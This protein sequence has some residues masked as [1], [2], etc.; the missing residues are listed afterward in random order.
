MDRPF[1]RRKVAEIAASL[2]ELP[3]SV[4]RGA[5]EDAIL[6]VVGIERPNG[7][8]V[9]VRRGLSFIYAD[10]QW[11]SLAGQLLD[12]VNAAPAS[13]WAQL[14]A[15]IDSLIDAGVRV[16][17]RLDGQ[18]FDGD[19]LLPLKSLQ[20]NARS[21]AWR[22]EIEWSFA[23]VA[24][25]VIGVIISLLPLDR[26]E[27]E[28]AGELTSVD[29][30]EEGAVERRMVNRYERSRSNRAIAILA[31]GR[32]CTVCGF[33]FSVAYGDWARGYVEIHHLEAMHLM[34]TPR[35]INPIEDLVP[36][37]SNCHRMVHRADP[38]ISPS[39]LRRIIEAQDGR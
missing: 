25:V 16:D 22:D 11:D 30:D 37:C 17:L 1:S 35:I 34:S 9:H 24:S 26:R 14:P 6:R 39:D 28:V 36:L 27:D 38:P 29:F 18:S 23:E 5:G 19:P 21:T 33:E 3:L 20:L 32:R 10:L 15:T 8:S 12:A 4:E 31:H 2:L 7:F 13:A